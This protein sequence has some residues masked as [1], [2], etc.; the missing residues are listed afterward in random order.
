MYVPV[1]LAEE[2]PQSTPQK[3]KQVATY[4]T[5]FLSATLYILQTLTPLRLNTDA[6]SYLSMASSAYDG[7]GF[8]D[9]LLPVGYPSIIFIMERLSLATSFWFVSFNLISIG[10]GLI[11][12]H[13]LF[14]RI[15]RFNR[16]ESTILCAT[17]LLSWVIVKHVTLP[18][19]DIPYFGV[20]A[21]CILMLVTV[22]KVESRKYLAWSLTLAILLC[23]AAISIRTIGMAL[24]PA[25]VWAI[26]FIPATQESVNRLLRQFP[27]LSLWAA[28][29]ALLAVLGGY[30]LVQQTGYFQTLQLN[31][32][33]KG[34]WNIIGTNIAFR[35]KELG[36][37]T[38]NLP[39]SKLPK[40]EM[41]FWVMGTITVLLFARGFWHQFRKI[42]P[43]EIYVGFYLLILFSW[44]FYDPRFWIPILPLLFGYMY[45]G[46]KN[47]QP[48]FVKPTLQ[49]FLVAFVFTGIIAL[50]YSTRITFAGDHFPDRY[51][52]G[53]L[54]N[55]YK[56]ASHQ[57]SKDEQ[58]PPLDKRTETIL[59]LLQ[60]YGHNHH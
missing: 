22:A 23:G 42:S 13:L 28:S 20:S 54:T 55:V 11:C 50:G 45:L 46:I 5:L 3:W 18:L 16:I 15:F 34:L 41:I 36:Q 29:I 4:S 38:S 33:E 6:V 44:P 2:S 17:T 37:I 30:Y 52:D 43:I 10:L 21:L 49:S 35:L 9:P 51:G 1:D 59:A 56:L 39:L 58:N 12:F 60:R 25:L 27:R 14:V 48:S 57:I 40:F 53:S 47:L 19:S 32:S 24:L 26:F 8:N 31:L 7:F